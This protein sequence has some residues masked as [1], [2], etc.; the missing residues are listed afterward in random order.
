MESKIVVDNIKIFSYLEVVPKISMQTFLAPGAKIIGNVEIGENS[1]V[2]YNCVLRGDVNYIKVG[3]STNIQDGTVVHVSSKEYSTEIG[4]NV[5]IGHNATIHG[6]KIKDYGF[7][8]MGATVLDGAVINSHSMVAAG[9]LVP[10]NMEVPTGA[11]VAGVPAKI[12]RK[13]T[14]SEIENIAK[15]AEH[16]IKIAENNKKSIKD[17]ET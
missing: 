13:L 5:T 7:V 2:W 10:P 15:S 9:A 8:G 1:S 4:D 6:C 14:E 11:L 17:L 3:K 16:Y 12:I